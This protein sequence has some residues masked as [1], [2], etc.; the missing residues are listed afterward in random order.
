MNLTIMDNYDMLATEYFRKM[1]GYRYDP[2]ISETVA[3]NV[4]FYTDGMDRVFSQVY[5][6][7]LG[8]YGSKL[9]RDEPLDFPFFKESSKEYVEETIREYKE[10]RPAFTQEEQE[11]ID[12]IMED[13]TPEQRMEFFDD[14]EEILRDRRPSRSQIDHK[15][16]R[17]S[18]E[19]FEE[20]REAFGLDGSLEKE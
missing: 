8:E 16:L 3:E 5:G 4:S 19:R 7:N 10:M 20:L 9:F 13:A 6:I 12:F 2:N 14:K 1:A 11:M 17:M 15:L 18:D